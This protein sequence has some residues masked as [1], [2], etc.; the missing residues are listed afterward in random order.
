MLI[1]NSKCDYCGRENNECLVIEKRF[2]VFF[3]TDVTLCQ[4]CVSRAFKLFSKC[5]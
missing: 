1:A 5:K 3:V 2:W 4:R